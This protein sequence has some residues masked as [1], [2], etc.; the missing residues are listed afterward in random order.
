MTLK[1]GRSASV[2]SMR[3]ALSDLYLEHL[4]QARPKAEVSSPAGGSRLPLPLPA[5][6]RVRPRGADRSPAGV[7]FIGVDL[8]AKHVPP[9]G[10]GSDRVHT[11]R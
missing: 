4:L 8:R 7:N 2:G 5:S 9:T 10:S 3:T 1:S 6:G 11:R